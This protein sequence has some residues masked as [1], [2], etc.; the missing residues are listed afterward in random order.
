MYT[1]EV[2]Q[3]SLLNKLDYCSQHGDT[4]CHLSTNSS[5]T[6]NSFVWEKE[7]MLLRHL[8][9]HEWLLWV[10]CDALI[11]NVSLSLDSVSQHAQLN[12]DLIVYRDRNFYNLGVLMIRSSPW[13]EWFLRE[14]LNMR[15]WI[16]YLGGSWRDQKAL[17][18]LLDKYPDIHSRIRVVEASVINSYAPR[19]HPGDFIYHQVNCK[20]SKAGGKA[21]INKCQ[22]KFLEQ[23]QRSREGRGHYG[24]QLN[25]KM[26]HVEDL[27]LKVSK[28]RP[29]LLES[30]R[31]M[32]RKLALIYLD[33]SKP[34]HFPTKPYTT[35][36]D[37]V[38]A[39]AR[40]RRAE[41]IHIIGTARIDTA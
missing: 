37:D 14:L 16:E 13:S 39:D 38:K 19:F 10:D 25:A 5:D 7:F 8:H 11:V 30:F 6:C 18:I 27:E 2:V 1:R 26:P 40:P 29:T 28:V 20:Y 3:R 31:C 4:T 34:H 12:E 22:S 36:H 9:E 15:D 23:A 32:V 21:K 33:T 17:T 24:Q 35:L 41:T